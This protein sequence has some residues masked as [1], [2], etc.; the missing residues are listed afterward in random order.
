MKKF[1]AL[2]AMLAVLVFVLSGCNLIG[3]DDALDDAQVVATV[4]G[5]EITKGEW[6]SYREYLA[7]Y[8]QQMYQQYGM[9]VTMSA[10]DI[11]ALGEPAL[12]QLVQSSVIDQKMDELGITPL[13]EEET[14]DIESYADNMMD[15]YKLMVRY[16][17]YPDMET[18]EE[19]AERLAKA[20]EEAAAT[21]DEAEE[22]TSDEAAETETAEA[23]ETE[24]TEAAETEAEPAA[25]ETAEAEEPKATVTDAQLDEM[26][27]ADL[28]ALGY[29]RDYFVD[30]RTSSVKSDKLHEYI[31]KDVTVSDEEVKAEFDKKAEEQKTSFDETIT[32]YLSAV[33]NNTDT[34]YVPEGYRGIKNLLVGFTDE[35]KDKIDTLKSELSTAQTAVTNAQSQLDS[36]REEDASDFDEETLTSFNEQIAALEQTVTDSQATVDEKTKALDEAQKAAY[37]AVRATAE[38][39]LARAKAGEDFDALVEEF[40]TDSGMKSEPNKSRGYLVCE[41]LSTYEQAFQDAAMALEKV[42]DISDELVETSY[43]YHILQYAQDIESG[44]VEYTDEI[45]EDIHSELLKTAQDAAYDA[46]VEQW[47]SEAD[48][49]TYPKV[50][51]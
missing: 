30:S 24:T 47:V 4:N 13:T 39:V 41:G 42:G 8:Y 15:W 31:N 22:K 33:N 9:S 25:T 48:V 35:D 11:E 7:S 12:E 3:H 43:G 17:N 1:V 16:Q 32:A 50:M 28:T 10:A 18:V 19:E 26:L 2:A 37:D 29:S 27:T 20:A 45:K 49:K 40:G 46:A 38:D 34:Y 21:P 6:K 44:I 51:K 14:A 36:M 23:T 5:K